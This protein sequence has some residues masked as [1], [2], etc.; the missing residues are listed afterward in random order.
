[1]YS[2]IYTY[3]AWYVVGVISSRASR[4]TC[5]ESDAG[6]MHDT[7]HTTR[8]G[9][10]QK[11]PYLGTSAGYESIGFASHAFNATG[12][13]LIGRTSAAGT[14]L[15]NSL[16]SSMNATTSGASASRRTGGSKPVGGS[17][18]DIPHEAVIPSGPQGQFET[19]NFFCAKPFEHYYNKVT[20]GDQ[21]A[22][23]TF[24]EVYHVTERNPGPNPR[25][26]VVKRFKDIREFRNV[27]VRIPAGYHMPF[28]ME[29]LD[30]F[31]DKIDPWAV[32]TPPDRALYVMPF[33]KGGTLD[34]L[35][36]GHKGH[37]VELNREM[38]FDLISQIAYGIWRLH[39][40]GIVHRDL[41]PG[42]IMLDPFVHKEFGDWY[43]VTIIDYGTVVPGHD[44][45]HTKRCKGA[46][47]SP[48]WLSPWQVQWWDK[49]G[50]SG[51]APYGPEAD[52][53]AF[54]VI[55]WQICAQQGPNVVPW[56]QN[57]PQNLA[58]DILRGNRKIRSVTNDALLID[59]M[60][61]VMT[62]KAFVFD[63]V[64]W[65]DT[66]PT[67]HPI[68]GHAY[69]Y[70]NLAPSTQEQDSPSIP[71][72]WVMDGRGERTEYHFV[73][74][75]GPFETWTESSMPTKE[76]SGTLIVSG[77]EQPDLVG[78]YLWAGRS[79]SSD[80]KPWYIKEGGRRDA[81]IYLFY[82]EGAWRFARYIDDLRSQLAFN[83][84]APE[85][86]DY[87]PTEK[88]EEVT[89]GG[90]TGLKITFTMEQIKPS[91]PVRLSVDRCTQQMDG[92]YNIYGWRYNGKPVYHSKHAK[93]YYDEA[94]RLWVCAPEIG[95][96]IRRAS[97]AFNNRDSRT[98][99]LTGWQGVGVSGACTIK[100]PI[101]FDSKRR[102]WP[103]FCTSYYPSPLFPKRYCDMVSPLEPSSWCSRE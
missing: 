44:Q 10:D 91:E 9:F 36:G 26:L 87:P 84:N 35:L 81:M 101:E 45:M 60:E 69:F 61:K 30:V 18:E 88:W 20:R 79:L 58:K 86:N 3:F 52:W 85:K 100:D 80:R 59:L 73:Q 1:M 65:F 78:I 21:V 7:V 38:K 28:N 83:G 19:P 99:P 55:V 5:K 102:F 14:R 2:P 95:I 17:P 89:P 68:L 56:N 39:V 41:K 98:V 90:R 97:Y 25:E 53:W 71:A 50:Y 63:P 54:G 13:G 31:Y 70:P 15:E 66:D 94:S 92:D 8:F 27:E 11:G 37:G 57:S 6:S 24:G 32:H 49:L 43:R 82:F 74:F 76:N 62:E 47:G 72:G 23:G 4:D 40:N 67:S 16:V 29:V 42:N 12:V 75:P 77:C 33:Y 48:L 51:G 96:D 34:M 93:L 46:I 64:K 22:Q 103:Q